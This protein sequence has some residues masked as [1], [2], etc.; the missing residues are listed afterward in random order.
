M[1]KLSPAHTYRQLIPQLLAGGIVYGLCLG[2]AYMTDRALHVGDL[3]SPAERLTSNAAA[4]TPAIE[5][6]QE[7]I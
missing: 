5:S 6:S 4:L 3:T 2:W 7:D 1:Q